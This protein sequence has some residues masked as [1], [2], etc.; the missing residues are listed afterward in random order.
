M[1]VFAI[2]IKHA[3]DVPVERP[4]NADPRMHQR[5]TAFRRQACHSGRR[6][7]QKIVGGVPMTVKRVAN[8]L[9]TDTMLFQQFCDRFSKHGDKTVTLFADGPAVEVPV[10][11]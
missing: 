2:R 1:R 11:F 9:D 10:F 3:L 7:D 4:D 8:I 5:T 6:L